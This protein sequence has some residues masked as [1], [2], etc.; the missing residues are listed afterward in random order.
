MRRFVLAIAAGAAVVTG[1]L[2]AAPRA[3]AMTAPAPA[4]LGA[5]IN[6]TTLSERVA[7]VCRRSWN[8]YRWVRRC[9]YTRPSY[10]HY[11]YRPYRYYRY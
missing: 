9:Y 6:E 1:S 10:R 11:R 5:A 7:Y 8:G 2:L 4:G 3:D